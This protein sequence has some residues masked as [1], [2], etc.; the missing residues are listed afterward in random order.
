MRFLC[1]TVALLAVAGTAAGATSGPRVALTDITPLTVAGVGF[2]A[3]T[4]VHVS[5]RFGQA[6][7]A[8]RVESTRTGRFVARFRRSLAE[9]SCTQVT[10]TATTARTRVTSKI[11]PAGEGCGAERVTSDPVSPRP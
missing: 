2:G 9:S 7:L 1:L 11:V 8:K 10:I 3:G 6:R 4:D 5:I